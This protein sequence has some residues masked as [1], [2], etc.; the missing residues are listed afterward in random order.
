MMP[1][2][3]YAI[4]LGKL[5]SRP[6]SEQDLPFMLMTYR[7][8]FGQI[9]EEA[10]GWDDGIEEGQLRRDMNLAPTL[11]LLYEGEMAGF[12]YFEVYDAVYIRHIEVHPDFNGRGI[13][14]LAIRWL[15]RIGDG[16]PIRVAVTDGNHRGMEF[17]TN[18]GFRKIGDVI[19]PMQGSR[20][21]Q[22][23]RKALM[24]LDIK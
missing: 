6:A 10:R 23:L 14:T 16:K 18:N 8:N 2:P 4:K 7:L 5:T 21:A 15:G 3:D 11:I 20:G 17:Y 19:L 1:E 24:Q 12:L 22:M 13:G 9:I